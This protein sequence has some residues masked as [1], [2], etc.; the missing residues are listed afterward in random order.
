MDYVERIIRIMKKSIN[1]QSLFIFIFSIFTVL[2]YAPMEM[3][4]TNTSDFWCNLRL[5]WW[6][7]IVVSIIVFAVV[8]FVNS[9]LPNNKLRGLFTIAVFAV[10]FCS[11]VQGN[12]LN[13]NLGLMNGTK[14]DWE[15]MSTKLRLNLVLWFVVILVIL[16]IGFYKTDITIKVCSY[17][18]VLLVLMQL[19]MFVYLLVPVIRDGGLKVKAE[20]AVS[21][22]YLCEVGDEENMI[23]LV[24]DS[25]DDLYMK[26]LINDNNDILKELDGFT[27][28]NNYAG[29]YRATGHGMIPILTGRGYANEKGYESFKNEMEFD[30]TY[31]G[32]LKSKGYTID[33]YSVMHDLASTESRDNMRNIFLAPIVMKGTKLKFTELIYRLAACKYLPDMFKCKFWIYGP[34]L[35]EFERYDSEKEIYDWYNSFLRDELYNNKLNVVNGKQFKLYHVYGAHEP[36]FTDIDLND[37]EE[38]WD[39]DSIPEGA[40]KLAILYLQRLKESGMYDDTTVII[41]SDHG[42]T[43]A[44]GVISSA[45]LLIKPKHSRGRI[46]INNAPV[47]QADFGATIVDLLGE[48]S[49]YPNEIPAFKVREG[50]KRNRKFYAYL[51]NKSDI[52][53]SNYF[54]EYSVPDDNNSPYNYTISDGI[55]PN[56]K[57]YNHQDYCKPCQDGIVPEMVNGWQIF[58]HIATDDLPK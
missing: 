33:V 41:T 48:E 4:L 56:G 1:S 20:Y 52:P 25:Y 43:H 11:Y 54:V 42:N 31:M 40:M 27:Y 55:L 17:L 39:V 7:P 50:E 15:A 13:A 12:F 19:T 6:I 21:T 45:S 10:G 47:S 34:E 37:C 49:S 9:I 3:F 18:S 57:H 26:K 30:K 28:F 51:H 36:Y 24:L 2:F 16:I 58:E 29:L 32:V 53:I 8:V 35:T 38:N 44:P 5:I 14:I 23:V 46:V 22:D